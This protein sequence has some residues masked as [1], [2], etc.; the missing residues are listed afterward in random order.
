MDIM[1][2]PEVGRRLKDQLTR[3][4]ATYTVNIEDVQ[5]KIRDINMSQPTNRASVYSEGN[6]AC[7]WCSVNNSLGL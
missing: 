1:V 3:S 5:V 2:S 7:L 4:G 6:P